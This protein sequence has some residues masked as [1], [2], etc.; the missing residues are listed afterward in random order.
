M[1]STSNGT[2]FDRHNLTVPERPVA[3][4]KLTRYLSENVSATGSERAISTFKSGFSTLVWLRKVTA[5]LP[6][7]PEHENLTPSLVASMAT[8]HSFSLI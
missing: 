6:I 8:I 7:S 3:L 4:Q 1:Y 2:S 5:P